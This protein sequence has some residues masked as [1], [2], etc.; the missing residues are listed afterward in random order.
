MKTGEPIRERTGKYYP[1]DGDFEAREE[2]DMYL[3]AVT[4]LEMLGAIPRV[5]ARDKSLTKA[6]IRAAI[7]AI[8]SDTVREF[9]LSLLTGTK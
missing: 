8:G 4:L 7:E 5:S 3:R 2:T 9:L 1:E 6:E